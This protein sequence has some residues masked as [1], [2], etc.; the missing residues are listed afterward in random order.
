MGGPPPLPLIQMPAW[1]TALGATVAAARASAAAAAATAEA[2]RQTATNLAEMQAIVDAVNPLSSVV[3]CGH[4]IDAVEA[5]LTGSDASAT[6][7]AHMDGSDAEIQARFHTQVDMGKTFDQAFEALRNAGPGARAIIF[8]DYAGGGGHV[9]MMANHNG[10]VGVFEG[11]DWGAGQPREIIATPERA[12]QRYNPSDV[13]F[14]I[15][16]SHP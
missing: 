8:V 9:I 13:G 12:I 7:P 1:L 6:A 16:G 15:V 5:R 4:I 3:N 10:T 2:A 11:Q 14:G